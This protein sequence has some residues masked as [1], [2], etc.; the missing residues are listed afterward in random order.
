MGNPRQFTDYESLKAHLFALK[1][2]GAKLGI[3]RMEALAGVLGNPERS[4]RVIHV[5]GTNGK[6]SVS[7]MSESILRAHGLHT[8][9]YTSPHLVHQG[10]RIQVDRVPI[11]EQG[12]VD[13]V[14]SILARI[15]AAGGIAEDEAPS[16]FEFMTGLAFVEFARRKVD[17]AIIEV[18][19]GGRLDAT[20]IVS[21]EVSVITSIGFDHCEILGDTYAK[22]AAEKAGIIKP[23]KPVVMGR[24]PA[25][26]EAVVREVAARNNS[27]LVSVREVFGEVVADYPVTNLEGTY[28]RWNAATALLAVRESGLLPNFDEALA[29]KALQRVEW[30]GRW[31][32]IRVA[33]GGQLILD[34][35]HNS[36]G[37]EALEENLRRLF[38]ECGCRPIIIA[39]TL[40][41]ARAQALIP[42]A[43]RHAERLH[44]VVPAQDRASGHEILEQAVPAG[45]SCEVVRSSVAELFPGPGVC[46]VASP[47]RPV[48]VTGSIYLLGEILQRLT[49][50]ALSGQER[51]QDW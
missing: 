15:E 21:P 9:L 51:L 4:L 49:Q 40:G 23:G 42:V 44:L 39:G 29:R 38:V 25:E 7:A 45:T 3:Q 26:A 17:A 12:I 35:S 47:E 30:A 5:A 43:A 37:A 8:G 19:L 20:N 28:Q 46:T 14:N 11:T 31:Q 50:P 22:I 34:A 27:R 48:V 32:R 18:G 2:R 10:E 36:E 24:L 1:A 6:G 13:G 33:G 16:F 41:V